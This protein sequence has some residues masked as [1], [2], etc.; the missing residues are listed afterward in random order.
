MKNEK[1]K[2]NTKSTWRT[3]KKRNWNEKATTCQLLF[4]WNDGISS[5]RIL[6]TGQKKNDKKL[7][8]FHIRSFLLPISLSPFRRFV[9][10]PKTFHADVVFVISLTFRKFWNECCGKLFILISV[11]LT[12]EVLCAK[13]EW[14]KLS[15]SD[16]NYR[17]KES[18]WKNNSFHPRG[19]INIIDFHF[20]FDSISIFCYSFQNVKLQTLGF[21][22][23][24]PWYSRLTKLNQQFKKICEYIHHA[25]S[26]L[27][28]TQQNFFLQ[29]QRKKV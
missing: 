16:T 4:V 1:K 23:W 18:G 29:H 20:M 21:T 22:T 12:V 28:H 8:I 9:F 15:N 13:F 7:C 5:N 2:K 25:Y 17:I 10:L 14:N 19:I 3:V 27:S 6:S 11:M 24:I 26:A